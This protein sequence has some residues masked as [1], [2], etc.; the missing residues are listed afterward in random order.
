MRFNKPVN[1]IQET[2]VVLCNFT[3]Q[4]KK[5]KSCQVL[6]SLSEQISFYF[7]IC[8]RREK[9]TSVWKHIYSKSVG[10]AEAAQQRQKEYSY[11]ELDSSYE[12]G[13]GQKR[14]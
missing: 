10:F 11:S 12:R 2:V 9:S 4:L 8:F 13:V 1:S 3:E 14:Y 5:K 7:E 6:Q